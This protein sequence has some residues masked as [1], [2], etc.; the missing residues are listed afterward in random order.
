MTPQVRRLAAEELHEAL[1]LLQPE[2]WDFEVPE[3]ERLSR[4]GGTLG[5]FD[6][7]RLVA[8]LSFVDHAPVRWVGNVV[9][10]KAQRGSGLGARLVQA[11]LD[12][13]AVGLYSVE[14][15]VTLY[16][17]LGFEEAGQAFA[18]RAESPRAIKVGRSDELMAADLREVV[19]LDAE[20]TGMDRRALLHELTRAY[21]RTVRVA[22]REGRVTAYGFAKTSATVTELGPIVAE[23]DASRDAVLDDLL[24]SAS[25]PF[26]ATT[27]DE[28]AMEALMERGF[29]RRFRTVTMF[30]GAP[31]KWR[32]ERLAA[33]AGLEK[34]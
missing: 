34:G 17:R 8:F 16:A 31:P 22:R 20:A 6:D 4:L 29:D 27:M 14:P 12:A 32:V 3:L 2:G 15:A 13:P 26:E 21:P 28:A 18:F 19:R 30:R 25:G 5:A 33:A 23:D 9:V 11:A 24:E 7:K 1:P 10:A